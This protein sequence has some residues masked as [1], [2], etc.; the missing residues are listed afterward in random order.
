MR[1][2]NDQTLQNGRIHMGRRKDARA[3]RGGLHKKYFLNPQRD[4]RDLHPQSEKRFQ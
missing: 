1:I 4:R 3:I 2:S